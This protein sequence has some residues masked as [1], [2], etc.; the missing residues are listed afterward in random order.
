MNLQSKNFQ[1]NSSA[2][3]EENLT[4]AAFDQATY[5][6]R[7]EE[8]SIE[9]PFVITTNLESRSERAGDREVLLL[10]EIPTASPEVLASAEKKVCK[11]RFHKQRATKVI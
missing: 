6:I 9:T 8:V 2:N 11:G 3:K 1:D 10:F 7:G 5:H 4:N